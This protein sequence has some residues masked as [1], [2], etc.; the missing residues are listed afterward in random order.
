MFVCFFWHFHQPVYK[1]PENGRFLLPWVNVHAVKN[2]RQ[3]AVLSEETAFPSTFNFVPC[4]L[5]QIEDYVLLKADDPYQRAMESREEDMNE[6]QRDLLRLIVPSGPKDRTIGAAALESLFSPVDKPDG[7]REGRLELR[8]RILE[9]LLPSYRSLWERGVVELT[10]SAGFHPL[11]PLLIDLAQASESEMPVRSFRRPED[12]AEHIRRGKAVFARFFG[13]EPSGFW[14]SEGGVSD[15]TVRIVGGQGFAY[16]LTDENVLWKS[17]ADGRRPEERMRPYDCHGLKILFRDR[18]ISDLIGFEYQRW[19]DEDAVSDLVGRLTSRAS[20]SGEDAVTLIALDGENPWAGYRD[21][22]VPFL[23]RLF[24]RLKNEPGLVPVTLSEY[25]K[26][27]PPAEAISLAS[28]TWLG[29]FAKWIGHPA[30]NEAWETLS[31]A[32][33]EAGPVNEIMVAEGSDWFWWSGEPGT[34][35]FDRLFRGYVRAAYRR[36]GLTPPKKI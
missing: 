24:G 3:M 6:R 36:A 22:G 32:R 28:G 5:E 8:R 31:R 23:R 2:Y 13:R 16:A 20:E 27:A 1:D 25:L 35:T 10:T 9:G 18:E 14:P 34:E 21:N 12:A 19:N 29:S 7:T 17:R 33:D 30:K 15:E 11:L 26:Q 4:L